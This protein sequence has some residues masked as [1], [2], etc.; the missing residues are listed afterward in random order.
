MYFSRAPT[1]T[2]LSESLFHQL[3]SPR[4]T[5]K[6]TAIDQLNDAA[7]NID[8]PHLRSLLLG[9]VRGE[10]SV[11][12]E[13]VDEDRS[14]ADTRSWLLSALGRVSSD[15]NEATD[16]IAKHTDPEAEPSYWARYWALERLIAGNNRRTP[17]SAEKVRQ[18][19]NDKLACCLALAF[20]ASKGDRAAQEKIKENF[21][22]EQYQWHALR[23]LRVIP[24]RFASPRLCELV[25][26][27]EYSD[28][29]YDAIIALGRLSN[30]ASQAL[31]AAQALTTA[32]SKMRGKPWLDGMRVA[33]I[34][35]LGNLK[36]ETSGPL[37]VEE[38]T[39]YNPAIVREAARSIEKILG[40]QT[41]LARIVE[42]A[43]KD[44]SPASTGA[45]ARAL[46]WMDRDAVAEELVDLMGSGPVAQQDMAR[47]LLSELG[48]A[49]AYEKLRALTAATK[50][51]RETLD[52]AEER[53]QSLFEQTVHEAQRG[54]QIATLMDLAIFSLGIIFLIASA[55]D[56]L[57][58]TGD[59]AAWAGVGSAG[60]LGVL[61]SLLISNPRRQVREAVDHLMRAKIIFLAYLRR[62]HQT[63]QAYTQ[64]LL[65]GNRVTIEQLKAYTDI[66]GTVME[67]TAEQL[68]DAASANTAGKGNT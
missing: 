58:K 12:T 17:E 8:Q 60:V 61:Y 5:E 39:D 44:P 11:E 42:A 32:V 9:A 34:T 28:E 62:L 33:A 1:P 65:S 16:E 7:I 27:A 47:S 19:G 13:R 26:K 31:P 30:E 10:Y 22:N 51:Y 38:L 55:F 20:L 6:Y 25:E 59:L 48:G 2:E 49:T 37:L 4:F 18:N 67:R 3:V 54:F 45:F 14:I 21:A 68:A 36:V 15:D 46:S 35:A 24:L 23:A 63:D 41:A 56:A 52:H 57:W 53:V 40:L 50:Q 66:V 43:V 64:L 29:T